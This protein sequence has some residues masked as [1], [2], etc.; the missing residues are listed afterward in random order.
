MYFE[1]HAHYDDERFDEDR[2]FLLKELP[3]F[4][5]KYVLNVGADVASSQKSVEMAE[6]F[7]Y[8]FAAVGVHPH[9]T[10]QCND[11]ALRRLEAMA[12]SKKVVAIGEIGLDF[13]YDNSKRENQRLWFREQLAL[14]KALELP[15]IIHS[16]DAAMETFEMIK[17]SGINQGVIHCYTGSK[18]MALAYAKLGFMIGIGGMITFKNAKQIV[19][20]VE[21]LPLDK[22][23][24]ETDCPYLS[25]VPNRGERNDS[26]NLKYI[27]EKIGI[28]KNVT[29]NQVEEETMHNALRVF[30]IKNNL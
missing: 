19:G 8:V 10:D 15:V 4:G 27:T 30:D 7:S 22:I 9:E 3:S 11:Q 14:A 20:T 13:Y 25:P 24:I 18:E 1:S 6:Q 12:A 16:R 26:R 29:H 5:V 28:I 21:A 23:L 17:D 2:E